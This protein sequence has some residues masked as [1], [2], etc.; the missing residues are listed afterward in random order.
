MTHIWR[1]RARHSS[2]MATPILHVDMDAFYASVEVIKDPSLKGKPV[3]VG[4]QGG[5]GVVTAASYEAREFG[6]HSAMPMVR[7]G[8]STYSGGLP[9]RSTRSESP[10][11]PLRYTAR[12]GAAWK[13]ATLDPAHLFGVRVALEDR[14]ELRRS[15][16]QIA[17]KLLVNVDDELL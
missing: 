8:A 15:C 1:S 4:G 10:A 9:F 11:W 2:E 13:L 16:L 6:V 7:A 3:I 17:L 12:F 5:R 14:I